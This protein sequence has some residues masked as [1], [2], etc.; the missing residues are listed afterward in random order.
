[1]DAIIWAVRTR[2]P[3]AYPRKIAEVLMSLDDP[4]LGLIQFAPNILLFALARCRFRDYLVT[5]ASC[6]RFEHLITNVIG[7]RPGLLQ[8]T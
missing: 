8:C 7:L 1:M 2:F 6:Y 4:P 3:D 5:L